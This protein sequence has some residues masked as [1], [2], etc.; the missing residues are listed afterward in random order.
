MRDDRLRI[1]VLGYLVRGP[2]GGMAWGSQMHYLAGLRALGHDVYLLEDSGD[3]PWACWD[4][5]LGMIDSTPSYGLSFAARALAPIGLSGR[6]AYHDAPRNRWHGPLGGRVAEVCANADLLVDIGGVNQA[7]PWFDGIPRSILLDLDPVFTQVATLTGSQRGVDQD[8]YSAFFTFGQNFGRDGCTMPDDGIPWQPTR[9]PV[10]LPSWPATRGRP[11]GRFTTVMQWESY[12]AVAHDGARYGLK[13]D[14]FRPYLK[15]PGSVDAELELSV[16]GESIPA[17]LL[18]RHQ[19][20]LRDPF[21][22]SD[23]P[24]AYQ[25]YIRGS[26]AEFTVAKHG[27]AATRSGWFSERSASYLATGRPVVTEE[28]GFSDWVE[29]GA[30][31]LAFSTFDEAAA[32][33]EEVNARYSHHCTA[34]REI[35][36]A[37]FDS[38][39]VLTDL[40]DRAYASRSTGCPSPAAAA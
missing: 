22:A 7:R 6:W 17:E 33:I 39:S 27:Y 19:W 23:T 9:P 1:V 28:T 2:I 3:A 11:G 31:V 21:D 26:K 30:G 12:P 32:A 8:R 10:H 15:L 29:P 25:A 14:S 13:V 24:E 35:A 20:H 40:L 4:P 16:G 36:E 5:R 34:A 38:R 37:H 18:R